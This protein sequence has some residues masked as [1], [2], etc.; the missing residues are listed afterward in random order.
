MYGS[1]IFAFEEDGTFSFPGEDGSAET[2]MYQQWSV[3]DDGGKMVWTTYHDTVCN[4][5]CD[6][7]YTLVDKAEGFGSPTVGA[8]WFKIVNYY[9][10]GEATCDIELVSPSDSRRLAGKPVVV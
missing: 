9:E 5:I 4:G 1:N 3:G 7:R 10:V 8:V 2:P 6:L